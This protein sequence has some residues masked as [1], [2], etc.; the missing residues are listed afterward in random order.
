M[1]S[2]GAM[3]DENLKFCASEFMSVDFSRLIAARTEFRSGVFGAD[4]RYRSVTLCH[5][6]KKQKNMSE[7]FFSPGFF[8]L[9]VLIFG[10]F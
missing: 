4:A 1:K 9:V 7:L 2:L 5:P 8:F 10:G 3:V 6:S